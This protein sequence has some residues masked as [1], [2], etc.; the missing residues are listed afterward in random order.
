MSAAARYAYLDAR[1]SVLAARLLS[2]QE[3][4]RFIGLDDREQGET[5]KALGVP[6]SE[7][8]IPD[9]AKTLEQIMVTCLVDEAVILARPLT[10]A[11]RDVLAYW[12]RRFEVVNLKVILRAVVAGVAAEDIRAALLDLGGMSALPLDALI[13]AEDT[14]ELLRRLERSGYARMARQAHSMYEEQGDLFS[15]ESALDREY[16]TGLAQRVNA[17]PDAD[18]HDLRRLT[19]V[20]V[21]QMNLV[22]LLRYRFVYGLEPAHAY[23]LLAPVGWYLNGRQLLSLVQLGST[24][25]VVQSAPPPLDRL[26]KDANTADAVETALRRETERIAHTLLRCTAFNLGRPCA[27]LLLR[28]RQLW[29]I[30]AALKGRQLGLGGDVIA[31]AM[32]LP[33]GASAQAQGAD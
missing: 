15:V 22:W 2:E 21:D 30:H 27:Y 31:S 6:L 23:Y 32:R 8:R 12:M 10:G 14:A 3:V 5:L 1:V 19:G 4:T 26:L 16:F 29:R 28:E 11:A 13:H 9:D 17:L 33:P 24:E 25:E 20:F 7:G 18:G